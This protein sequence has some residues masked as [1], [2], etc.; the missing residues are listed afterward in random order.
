M[1]RMLCHDSYR[2][3]NQIGHIRIQHKSESLSTLDVS[4][5]LLVEFC[6]STME[7]PA[8]DE[9]AHGNCT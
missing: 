2:Y 8:L 9:S 7:L 3:E 6:Y 4:T 1:R 5:R